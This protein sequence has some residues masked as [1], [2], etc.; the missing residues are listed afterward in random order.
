MRVNGKY[1]F[2]DVNDER[3]PVRIEHGENAKRTLNPPAP[4]LIGLHQCSAPHNIRLSVHYFWNNF[5]VSPVTGFHRKCLLVLSDFDSFMFH[6]FSFSHSPSSFA[7]F[8]FNF[9]S[10]GS[11]PCA[12]CLGTVESTLTVVVVTESTSF[13]MKNHYWNWNNV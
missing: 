10:F 11:H 7:P 5:S 9:S 12:P 4:H 8:S 2:R 13:P 1:L 3:V 6:R